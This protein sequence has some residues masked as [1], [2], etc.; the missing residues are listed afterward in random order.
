MVVCE[1]TACFV[2]G[3]TDIARETEN[4]IIYRHENR[5]TCLHLSL[6]QNSVLSRHQE[7]IDEAIPKNEVQFIVQIC[8]SS[9]FLLFLKSILA[10][11]IYF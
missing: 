10:D 3:R 4:P 5:I 8:T 7:E 2:K 11:V 1:K 6:I 9:V